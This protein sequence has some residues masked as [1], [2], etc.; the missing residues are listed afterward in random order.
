MLA[1]RAYVYEKVQ[2]ID[3]ELRHFLRLFIFWGLRFLLW[4]ID[5]IAAA[6]YVPCADSCGCTEE[7]CPAPRKT[8]HGLILS[9]AIFNFF[10]LVAFI[11]FLLIR[12]TTDEQ[13][14]SS[15]DRREAA[16]VTNVLLFVGL[17]LKLADIGMPVAATGLCFPDSATP[18][19]VNYMSMSQCTGQPACPFGDFFALYAIYC[20][21][22]VMIGVADVFVT[23]PMMSQKTYDWYLAPRLGPNGRI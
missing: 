20:I 1:V 6:S 3:G 17:L 15:G 8:C 16:T 7:A 21:M 12:L 14:S 10:T 19:Y 9:I 23:T 4:L 2:S 11:I 5:M 22:K 18:P 13:S